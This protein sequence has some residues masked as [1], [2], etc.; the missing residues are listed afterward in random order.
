MSTPNPPELIKEFAR[1][2][3]LNL[4]FIE[5]YARQP[6]YEVFEITQL[7]NS[8]LGLLLLPKEKLY[9][10]IPETALFQLEKEGWPTIRPTGGE[11]LTLKELVRHL[12]NA[13][14]HTHFEYY[15]NSANE[16]DYLIIWD[17][18][19]QSKHKNWELQLSV[20]DL[21]LLMLRFA[22]KIERGEIQ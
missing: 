14:A 7:V 19:P 3:R 12:R 16:I 17:K 5:Q 2:T 8:A 6:G 20:K 21:R 11:S 18:A 9:D 22:E 1:R 4:E 10:N 13:F 15:S